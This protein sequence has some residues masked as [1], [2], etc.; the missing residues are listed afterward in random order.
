[1][2]KRMFSLFLVLAMLVGMFPAGMLVSA[3]E[4]AGTNVINAAYGNV[5]LDG[6]LNEA[7]Q[8]TGTLGEARFGALYSAGY[9]Y[10]GFNAALDVAVKLNGET[11]TG[12][13]QKSESATE[14]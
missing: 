5:S 3:Q 1:M 2:H 8:L 9:L 7:W 13:T 11:V 6:T 4:Q 10:L 12:E 14:V